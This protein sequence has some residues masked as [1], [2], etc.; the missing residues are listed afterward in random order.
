MTRRHFAALMCALLASSSAT[1]QEAKRT[2]LTF[3]LAQPDGRSAWRVAEVSP[4]GEITLAYGAFGD[5]RTFGAEGYAFLVPK[6][7][8]AALARVMVTAVEE[9]AALVKTS[10]LAAKLF[11]P[12]D[13][14]L[15]LHSDAEAPGFKAIPEKINLPGMNAEGRDTL[16]ELREAAS[17]D[18]SMNNL[19]QIGLAMHNWNAANGHLPPAVLRGPDG[20]PR[21]SW[22]VSI[23]PYING[24]MATYQSYDFAQPWDS[25]KNLKLL[26]RMPEVY[27]DPI[28][29][30]AKGHF[31][32]YAMLVGETTPFPPDGMTIKD[33]QT[34]ELKPEGA[35]NFAQIQDGH[36]NTFAVVCV[37]PARKIPWTKPEDIAFGEDFPA[38]GDPKGIALPYK[39][40]GVAYAPV[41]LMDGAVKAL[42]AKTN[43]ATVNALA[44]RAGGE[45]VPA[46]VFQRV[47]VGRGGATLT[48]V[49][50]G[51]KATATIR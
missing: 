28:Y 26:D 36:S 4:T 11:A 44:T 6:G 29:G 48:I 18:R 12:G 33:D 24:G 30:D 9:K 22:R 35:I 38:L 31:T 41:L 32:N 20:K 47:G 37:S 14:V 17:R 19:K 23:L 40:D 43:P 34:R 50:E 49:V 3:R 5:A 1:A 2:E 10:P 16:Q 46:D 42:S 45:V 51:G 13:D 25:P 39:I 7:K 27:R 15:L 21:H 8:A